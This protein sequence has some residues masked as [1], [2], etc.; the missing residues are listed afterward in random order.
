MG[1]TA[2]LGQLAQKFACEEAQHGRECCLID[3]DLQFGDAAFQLGLQPALTVADLIAGRARV[4]G[5]MLRSIAAGHSSGLQV[6]A[7]PS[8]I[9]PL[10]ALDSDP[11]MHILDEAK[12][13]FGTVF[14]D[15][16]SNWTNWS[17]SLLASADLVLMVT[18]LSIPSLHRARRQLDLVMQHLGGVRI[19]LVVN[20]FEKKLFGKLGADDVARVLGREADYLVANDYAVVS[21]AID[22]GVPV[23]EIRRKGGVTRDLNALEAGV[24]AAL[25]RDR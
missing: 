7:A 2:I 8:E 12:S 18:Q 10:E 9:L 22:R 19:Q 3:L 16:P 6:I 14:V 1:A 21:E 20:R 25:G 13:E 15:L 5:E 23:S 11:L 17:L 4:D 24:A